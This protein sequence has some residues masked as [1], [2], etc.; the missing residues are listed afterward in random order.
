MHL[1]G[2][3]VLPVPS[4]LE[5]EVELDGPGTGTIVGAAAAIPAFLGMQDDR[6]LALF[7]MR[8]VHID[9]ACFNADVASVA[10]I[11]IEDHRIIRCSDIRHR[12][13]FFLRHGI[14]LKFFYE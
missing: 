10:D 1:T 14:L 12:E 6:R 3:F 2:G 13:Y 9:L 7:R 8:Y 4:Q 5:R 11:R